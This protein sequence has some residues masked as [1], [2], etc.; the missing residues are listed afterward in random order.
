M[1]TENGGAF[2][3]AVLEIKLDEMLSPKVVA[4]LEG[5]GSSVTVSVSE[6]TVFALAQALRDKDA[7]TLSSEQQARIV[8]GALSIKVREEDGDESH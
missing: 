7:S 1:S 3:N 2:V 8:L 4:R 5:T 6:D